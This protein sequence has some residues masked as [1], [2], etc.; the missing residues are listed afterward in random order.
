MPL[1]ETTDEAKRILEAARSRKVTLRLFG[2]VAIFF[3]CPSARVVNPERQYVDIDVMGH[4]KQSKEIKNL[5]T[6]LGYVPRDRF[7]AMHGF[8]RLIFNDLEHARRADIFL[9]L[10]E[11][12]HKF[13]FK[14][15][16]DMEGNTLPLADLLATKLQIFE[17]NEKDLKDALTIFVDH[18]VG[19]NDS[20]INGAY[21]ADICANDWGTYKTFRIN[22]DKALTVLEALSMDTTRKELAKSRIAKFR[23]MMEDAP[24]SFRWKLR[25]QV[26]ESVKWYELPEADQEV[27]D[28]RVAR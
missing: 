19:E 16:I 9:D 20:V 8:R 10:F 2:G 6:D 14:K 24:K 27:V 25:A 15:R 12:S 13:N 17:I 4:G 23:K 1:A 18:D 3:S 11:M 21:L 7:N 26:G 5:F 22:L 28:S